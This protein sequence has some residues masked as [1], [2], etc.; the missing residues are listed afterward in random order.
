M[1]KKQKLKIKKTAYKR[2]INRRK[3]KENEK[4]LCIN[5]FYTLFEYNAYILFKG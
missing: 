1:R 2:K 3:E 4:I 5:W